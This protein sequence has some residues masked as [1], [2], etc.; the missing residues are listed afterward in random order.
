MCHIGDTKCWNGGKETGGRVGNRVPKND[1]R[2]KKEGKRERDRK[3]W[4]SYILRNAL[5]VKYLTRGT[6]S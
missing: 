4:D 5:V 1:K 3:N 2:G 6:S